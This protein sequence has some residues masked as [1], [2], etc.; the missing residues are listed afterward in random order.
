[1]DT[2]TR[3]GPTGPI[4]GSDEGLDQR[5]RRDRHPEARVALPKE[6]GKNLAWCPA[7]SAGMV[8]RSCKRRC[9][10]CGY[11]EDCSNLI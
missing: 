2:T 11:F 6:E 1:M 8:D 4:T 10:R 7:C 9:P 5:A 3:V